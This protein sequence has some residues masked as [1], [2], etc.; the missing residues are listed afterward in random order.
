M[1]SFEVLHYLNRKQVGKDGFMALK[2]DLSKAYDKY[3][4]LSGHHALG[5]IVPTRGIRQGDPISFYIFWTAG[6]ARESIQ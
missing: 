3:T 6:N 5:P 4:V 1:I 2:L